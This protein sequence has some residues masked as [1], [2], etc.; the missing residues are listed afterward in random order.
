MPIPESLLLEAAR[1]LMRL[2][3]SWEEARQSQNL[4]R[5]PAPLVL[6]VLQVAQHYIT[7]TQAV[8][9]RAARSVEEALEEIA[10]LAHRRFAPAVVEALYSLRVWLNSE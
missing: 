4:L 7:A 8:E 2:Q 1:V 6:H 10:A 9:G 5:E 3:T